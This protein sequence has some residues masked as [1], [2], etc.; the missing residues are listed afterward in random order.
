M[1]QEFL[2]N[3]NKRDEKKAIT[4]KE[5]KERSEKRKWK[6]IWKSV[7]GKHP[8]LKRKLYTKWWKDGNCSTNL[9]S[10]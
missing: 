10:F 1:Q 8:F 9:L 6:A 2:N 3:N 7:S 4:R 5:M